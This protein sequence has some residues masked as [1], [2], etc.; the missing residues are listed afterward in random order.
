VVPSTFRIGVCSDIHGHA[1]RLE[2][3][4]DEMDAAGVD[5]R[6]CLGDLIGGGRDPVEVVRLARRSFDL[7]LMGNHDAWMLQGHWWPEDARKLRGRDALW[8]A[9]L[10]P[11]CERH[12]IRCWHGSPSQPLLAF[13]ND[14][15]A[16][17]ELRDLAPGTIGLVGHTHEPDAY[18]LERDRVIE[19]RP[20]AGKTV[21]LNPSWAMVANPGAV[22]GS[23]ADHAARWLELDLDERTARWHRVE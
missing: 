2:Q 18:T 4:L 3:V 13:F 19:M 10:S 22:S 5:E 12:G 8:I 15:T 17:D 21:F 1:D 7:C 11:Q 14:R 23:D 9:S 20:E 16:A 6:W